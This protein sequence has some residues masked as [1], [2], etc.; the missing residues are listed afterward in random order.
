MALKFNSTWRL[1]KA[2]GYMNHG[3]DSIPRTSTEMETSF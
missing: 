1:S 3:S 2:A